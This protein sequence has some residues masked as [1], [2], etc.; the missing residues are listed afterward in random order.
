[1][2]EVPKVYGFRRIGDLLTNRFSKPKSFLR[3]YP[4]QRHS[5]VGHDELHRLN[6]HKFSDLVLVKVPDVLSDHC[7]TLVPKFIE[8]QPRD[9]A[10]VRSQTVLVHLGVEFITNC[11][12]CM[13][14]ND[15]GQGTHVYQACGLFSSAP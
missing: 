2:R 4:I 6:P 14:S 9:Y 5:S 15:T 13:V 3:R 12:N 10:L 1:M 7:A 8:R 11:L